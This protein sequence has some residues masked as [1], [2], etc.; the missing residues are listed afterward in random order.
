MPSSFLYVAMDFMDEAEM[1][2][3]AEMLAVVEGNFGFK[4]NDDYISKYTAK[5]AVGGLTQF[6]RRIFA[7]TKMFK[8]R[9]RMINTVNELAE[10]GG[11]EYTNIFA[12][13]G[14]KMLKKVV[15]ATKDSGVGILGITILTHMDEDYCQEMFRRSL[16]DAVRFLAEVSQDSG[17]SGI[18]LPGTCLDAVKDMSIKKVVPG[19]RPIWYESKKANPQAQIVTPKPAVKHGADILVAGS[20]VWDTSNPVDSL[21]RILDEMDI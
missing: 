19:I 17:C 2:R 13:V 20:P 9:R 14:H 4:V 10:I 8:G 1:L 12:L 15:Q 6:N 3:A 5:R 21:K 16:P 7:D 11:V 18:I